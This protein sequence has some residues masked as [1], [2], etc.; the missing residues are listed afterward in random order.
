MLV[1]KYVNQFAILQQN[2]PPF[3]MDFCTVILLCEMLHLSF[4]SVLFCKCC[5]SVPLLIVGFDFVQ[6]T[7]TINAYRKCMLKVCV[8]YSYHLSVEFIRS[9]LAYVM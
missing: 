4:C 6:L 3:P 9:P 1:C 5:K 8:S 7:I 2:C